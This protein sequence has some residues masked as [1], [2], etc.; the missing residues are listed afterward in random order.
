M[1]SNTLRLKFCYSKL[2]HILHQR[3]HP[4]VIGHILKNKQKNKYF[5][6]QEIIQSIIMKMMMKMKNRSHRYDI[7]DLHLYIE[8]NIY[9]SD[10]DDASTPNQHLKLNSG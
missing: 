1:L 10:Y 5:F 8:A 3:Y 9:M 4:E 2:L 7:V 6:I